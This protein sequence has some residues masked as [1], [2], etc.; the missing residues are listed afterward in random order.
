MKSRIFH[1]FTGNYKVD[2][3]YHAVPQ[4][5]ET[6]EG[7]MG[8]VPGVRTQGLNTNQA[9]NF[10]QF[11]VDTSGNTVV[12][13]SLTVTGSKI[14]GK[15]NVIASASAT[16]TLTAAQT[17]AILLFDRASGVTYTL[18]APA[19]GLEFT[20]IVTVTITS[21]NAKVITD[22]GTTLLAGII[23]SGLDN[24]A[25]KQWVGNGSSHL[26]VTQN[27]TTTGGI[28]GS[29]LKFTCVTTTLWSVQ[30]MIVASGTTAT[31]FATS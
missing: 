19:L 26:A 13:G 8:G 11:T 15:G 30:G 29:W 22:A 2:R 25:N 31:P 12:P 6:I 28:V 9:V 27:G 21:S 7:M 17:G 20:F 14:G 24:T 10:S 5:D 4:D 16:P 3:L 1:Q 23:V 18:P